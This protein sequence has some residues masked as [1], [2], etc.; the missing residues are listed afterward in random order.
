MP[1]CSD[2]TI[3]LRMREVELLVDL[4]SVDHHFE[5]RK[6][7]ATQLSTISIES[8]CVLITRRS[9]SFGM[10][11]TSHDSCFGVRPAINFE[12]ISSNACFCHQDESSCAGVGLLRRGCWSAPLTKIRR[13]DL[14]PC[15]MLR[16]VLPRNRRTSFQPASTKLFECGPAHLPRIG[17]SYKCR[18][19]FFVLPR[20][21]SARLS[22]NFGVI[23]ATNSTNARM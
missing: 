9:P 17:H 15:K 2:R 4:R 8:H 16:R 7:V 13:F 22:I 18:R 5:L 21:N 20:T 3:A 23:S 11:F 1:R 19:A 12:M 14:S 10:I 6:S